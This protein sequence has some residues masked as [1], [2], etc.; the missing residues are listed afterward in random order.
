MKKKLMVLALAALLLCGCLTVGVLAAEDVIVLNEENGYELNVKIHLV[1]DINGDGAI[2]PS[3]NTKVLR[4]IKGTA[5]LDGYDFQCG[6]INGDGAITPS[7]STK[8]LRYIKGTSKI[9]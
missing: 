3:D 2:T 4:H 7:D 6:D 5:K 8:M 1:G 9:W